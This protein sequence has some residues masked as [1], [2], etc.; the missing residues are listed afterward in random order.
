MECTN[1]K[2]NP[3]CPFCK[4]RAT[5]EGPLKEF[6]A[7]AFK[8]HCTQ[9]GRYF[10][11]FSNTVFWY[12]EFSAETIAIA[13]ELILQLGLSYAQAKHALK[14]FWGVDV[15]KSIF[16]AWVN[17]FG[18]VKLPKPSYT[19]IWHIDEVFIKHEQRSAGEK[20]KFF[21][22]LW[23]V[24][25]SKQQLI[26]LH[27]SEKRDISAAKQALAK[28]KAA[29]GFAPLIVVSDAYNVYPH[30]LRSVLRST[31]HVTAHFAASIFALHGRIWS[32]SNNI[33]ESL[34]SRIR[35]R[36]RRRRGLKS[37]G[38]AQLFLERL[39]FVWNGR[40]AHSLARALLQTVNQ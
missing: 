6:K 11:T 22:Y 40:F 8:Y 18:H 15:S 25:D 14:S 2:Q 37:V 31:L 32:L 29:A 28:A 7:N 1:M 34:N 9:C 26:A 36:L 17:N 39:A 35:D 21:T 30:A 24:C 12:A 20:R 5:R 38:A 27:H 19:N 3:P 10:S 23:V 33:V 13:L 16:T 4:G